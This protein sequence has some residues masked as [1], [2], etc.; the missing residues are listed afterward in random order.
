VSERLTDFPA[1]DA[2]SDLVQAVRVR[3]TVYCRSVMRAP[4]GLGVRARD[5]AAFH[6][7]SDGE[8]VLDVEGAEAP[9]RLRGGD[10]DLACEALADFADLQSPYLVGR[11]RAVAQLAVA[12]GRELGLGGDELARVRL[13]GLTQD[14]GRVGVS[15][16]VWH[17]EG[18]LSR[19]D[20]E[21]VRLHPYTTARVVGRAA[22][23]GEVAELAASHHER[24][25]ASGYHRSVPAPMLSR[26][27]RVLA[28]AD[29]YRA[30]LEQRPHRPAYE[31]DDAARLLREEAAAGR[32][33][34]PGHER[35]RA[36][37]SRHLFVEEQAV[38]VQRAEV[39][40]EHRERAAIGDAGG[41]VRPLARVAALGE[42]PAELVQ[43]RP[44]AQ[45]PVRV[46][47][48]ERDRRQ[49]FEKWPRCSNASSPAE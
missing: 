17:K 26:A 34:G 28:A 1:D 18:S 23:L 2:V 32:L 7:V 44:L 14:L 31:P 16:G 5:T 42:E 27:A 39:R 9:R 3:T 48:D 30:L 41:D 46:V 4:W 49:Y 25:D 8:C 20:W 33:D 11:S 24:L 36:D 12:A 21:L 40:G 6:L 47:V 15:A 45:D 43:R 10:L 13:A 22:S 37:R 19:A 35:G 38:G 29:V